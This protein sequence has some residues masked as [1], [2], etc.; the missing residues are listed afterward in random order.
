MYTVRPTQLATMQK[1]QRKFWFDVVGGEKSPETKAQAFGT[2]VHTHL[3]AWF[4]DAVLPPDTETGRVARKGL[5]LL[6]T[7]KGVLTRGVEVEVPFS[8]NYGDSLCVKSSGIDAFLPHATVLIDHKTCASAQWIP[9]AAEIKAGAQ[10]ITYA[11]YILNVRKVDH[12]LDCL[13][14]YYP[15]NKDAAETRAFKFTASGASTAFDAIAHKALTVLQHDAAEKTLGNY[16]ACR[17]FG[18]CQFRSRCETIKEN[19]MTL[20]E[21]I[22]AARE[23]Q[24]PQSTAPDNISAVNPPD[25]EVPTFEAAPE[26]PEKKTRAKKLT[27]AVVPPAEPV[28][29]TLLIGCYPTKG[30]QAQ[31]VDDLLAPLKRRV[32]E[33][34][35]VAHWSLVDF[36]KG[37]GLLAAE[38]SQYL[39]TNAVPPVLFIDTFSPSTKAVLDVLRERAGIVLQAI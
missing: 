32:C 13:W 26:V 9:T 21:K 3:A 31:N 37:A 19:D 39:D 12:E 24:T 16:A 2:E 5:H 14:V 34:A 35:D 23:A 11:H 6:P 18:G 30:M 17:D 15:K 7:P 29:F 28:G 4:K 38:L 20:L 8:F 36:A 25:A 1:C 10:A 33:G 27:P 22:K